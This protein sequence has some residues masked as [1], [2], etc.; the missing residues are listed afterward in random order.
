MLK[1]FTKAIVLASAGA[2]LTTTTAFAWHVDTTP[3]VV[4]HEVVTKTADLGPRGDPL[5]RFV[6]FPKVTRLEVPGQVCVPDARW[7][8]GWK[9]VV[10]GTDVRVGRG[11][12]AGL[13]PGWYTGEW[14]RISDGYV[15]RETERFHIERAST[16]T[17]LRDTFAVLHIR[18]TNGGYSKRCFTIPADEKLMTPWYDLRPGSKYTLIVDGKVA[19]RGRVAPLD[20]YAPP[21]RGYKPNAWKYR[22][23]C[24]R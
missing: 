12:C 22:V 21:W 15:L 19:E 18:L 13:N 10:R 6:V 3:S 4:K 17:G 1:R 8:Q 2:L 14:H 9:L 16:T 5:Y 23:S 7:A 24:Q 20:W 11:L